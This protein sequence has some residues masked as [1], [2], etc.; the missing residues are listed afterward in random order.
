MKQRIREFCF[1][2]SIICTIFDLLFLFEEFAT[3]F[4]GYIMK[5]QFF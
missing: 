4:A 5:A 1:V 2:E 3:S